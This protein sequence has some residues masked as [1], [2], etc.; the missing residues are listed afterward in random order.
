MIRQPPRSTPLYSSA[1]SDV[2]KRQNHHTK[3]LIGGNKAYARKKQLRDR[4]YDE[5][6][7]RRNRSRPFCTQAL[8]ARSA[9]PSIVSACET[10]AT[11]KQSERWALRSLLTT[12]F[13]S[14]YSIIIPTASRTDALPGCTVM[15]MYVPASSATSIVDGST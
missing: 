4:L 10:R 9:Y 15:P 2:Y 14:G 11:D 7:Y 8:C 5:N 6:A 3:Y 1:A 12:N 13:A